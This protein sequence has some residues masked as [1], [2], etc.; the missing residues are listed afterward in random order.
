[1]LWMLLSSLGWGATIGDPI[2]RTGIGRVATGV[3]IESASQWL[4]VKDCAPGGSCD[5]VWRRSGLVGVGRITLVDGL[6]VDVEVGRLTDRIQQASYRGSGYQWALG[7]RGALPLGSSGWWLSAV[8]R[9]SVGLG[10]NDEVGADLV[11][12]RFSVGTASGLLAWSPIQD[13]GFTFWVGGQGAWRWEHT[14]TPLGLDEDGVANL[15]V[16]MEAGVPVAAVAGLSIVSE[17]LGAPWQ[18]AWR[19]GVE[20]DGMVGQVNLVSVQALARF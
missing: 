5:G 17:P 13:A 3:R 11:E 14:V 16:P 10:D 6:G 4:H 19:L 12:N 18:P 15:E 7:A 8:G 20:L 2:P 1:M 9:Y